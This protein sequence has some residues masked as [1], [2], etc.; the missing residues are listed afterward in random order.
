MHSGPGPS[1]PPASRPYR[2]EEP[3]PSES[4]YYQRAVPYSEIIQNG[5]LIVLIRTTES[6]PV[7]DSGEESYVDRG[8][9][10]EKLG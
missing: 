4:A 7:R 8:R 10:G 5:L 6:V 2:H 1:Q 9:R 3:A